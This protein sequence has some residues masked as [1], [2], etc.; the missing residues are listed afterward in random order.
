MKRLARVSATLPEG[1]EG[2]HHHEGILPLAKSM[3]LKGYSWVLPGHG[4]SYF[5]CGKLLI[6][7]CLNVDEHTQE[8]LFEPMRGKAYVQ[9]KKRTCL[10]AECPVCYEK[11]AGKE[12]EKIAWRLSAW[13]GHGKIIHVVASPKLKR[14][15]AFNRLRAECYRILRKH[16]VL[17][18]SV[19]FH[20]FRQLKNSKRWY[21]SPHFHVLGYGWVVKTKEGY[22]NHGWVVK[23]I[24]IR[25][26]VSGTALYQLSHCGIRKNFHSVTWFGHLSY[27]KLR[28]PPR[29]EPEKETCPICGKVLRPL[30]YFGKEELPTEEGFYWLD[31]EGFVLKPKRWDYG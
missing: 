16:G 3:S 12:A 5:D 20:P 13:S 27:N 8:G 14:G 31:P 15:V 1:G 29:P 7:G 18:G 19:I 4:N 6:F 26:T 30:Y 24:G 17:G 21:L 9:M 2:L 23:N 25:K 10:R 11:W 28:V 22:E